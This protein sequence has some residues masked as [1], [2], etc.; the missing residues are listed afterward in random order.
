MSERTQELVRSHELLREREQRFE[1]IVTSAMDGIVTVDAQQRIVLFNGAA[2][3][4]FG[5]NAAATLGQQLDQ[6]IPAR[7]HAVHRGQ[8]EKFGRTRVT[9]RQMGGT[10]EVYGLRADGNEF[11][12]EASISQIDESGKKMFTAILRDVTERKRA[13]ISRGRLAAVVESSDDAI[14]SKTLNSSITTWNDG[15]TRMFGYAPEEALG[16]AITMLIPEDRLHEEQMILDK[17]VSG[18]TVRHYETVRQ[19]KDGTQFDVSITVSPVRDA[20]GQLTGAASIARDITERRR[21]E[22]ALRAS[23][24]QLRRVTEAMPA[25]I[26][27][28][29]E[30]QRYRFVNRTFEQWWARPRAEV[31]DKPVKEVVGA[32]TY[33]KFAHNL[34]NALAG[35][36]VSFEHTVKYGDGATRQVRTTY[37]PD[38]DTDGRTNGVFVL[39]NDLTG[40]KHAEALLARTQKMESLG[41]LAGGIAHDFNNILPAIRG[42]TTIAAKNL[43]RDHPAQDSL[44]QIEKAAQRASDLVRRILAFSRPQEHAV[45]AVDLENVT[46]E[47]LKLLRA[48]LPATIELRIDFAPELPEVAADPTQIYQIV[49]NLL[50]NAAYAIGTQGGS[51]ELRLSELHADRKI[52]IVTAGLSPGRYVLLTVRDSGSGMDAE[53]QARIFDP[54]FTTKPVGQGTGLGMSI[55]HGIMKNIG[56]A[57]TVYSEAG[58]GSKFHL[59][60]RIAEATLAEPRSTPVVTARG[61]GQR[62]LYVDDEEALVFLATYTLTLLGY[63]IT[64]RTNAAEALLEFAARP[65]DF[66][67]VV[68]D[69]S[70]PHMS[71]LDFARAILAIRSDVPVIVASGYVRPEDEAEARAIGVREVIEK[72]NTME[73]YAQVL[74]RLFRSGKA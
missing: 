39:V 53:T 5:R 35:E 50:T 67:V 3:K 68:S 8:V 47:A 74:D 59:Y 37:V 11:P 73:E 24:M 10:A 19:R 25:M 27:Y 21:S 28:I 49:V 9:N 16:K 6:L 30:Q 23:E 36:P 44:A 7:F 22:A 32:E 38:I 71:G 70:M 14:I 41:T 42:F 64:G 2:E 33:E 51:I 15:A 29:D 66:D 52:A 4:I 57:I 55:V 31:L 13:E 60:F 45:Q 69:L 62:I 61:N 65:H 43:P 72:P 58:K 40:Q 18:Q 46:L 20:A 17:I 12:L 56:G 26:A 34:N 54:F 1:G 48:T 63:E